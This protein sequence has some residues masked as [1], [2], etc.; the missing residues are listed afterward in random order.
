[1]AKNIYKEI[2]ERGIITEREINLIKNR[3][4]RGINTEEIFMNGPLQITPEQTA[5]GLAWLKNL[6][7]TPHGRIRKNNPFNQ[8]QASVINKFRKFELVGFYDVGTFW[9]Y[10]F[11][12]IY[13][14]WPTKGKHFSYV[15][16]YNNPK[17]PIRFIG[18]R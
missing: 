13:R 8:K 15:A 5:K 9:R 16:T 6:Y 14:V 18:K 1:M 10:Y 17:Q 12:P 11:V 7:K 3:M 2:A 4:N